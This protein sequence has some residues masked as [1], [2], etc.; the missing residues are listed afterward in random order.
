[1]VFPFRFAVA[2][3]TGLIN[4]TPMPL[5][6]VELPVI[7]LLEM[8]ALPSCTSIP[9]ELLLLTSLLLMVWLPSAAHIPV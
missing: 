8:V 2:G 9:L 1:M 7:R 4:T 6:L 5:P 3:P